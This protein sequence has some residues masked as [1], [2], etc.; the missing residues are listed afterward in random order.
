MREFAA[1]EC[2]HVLEVE[3]LRALGEGTPGARVTGEAVG[4]TTTQ[5][6]RTQGGERRLSVP[7]CLQV[8][9]PGVQCGDAGVDSL[10]KAKTG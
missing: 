10:G 6:R 8:V 9:L 7:P 4:E 1:L 3:R 2:E 5:A